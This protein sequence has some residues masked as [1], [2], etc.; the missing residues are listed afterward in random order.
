[1]PNSHISFRNLLDSVSQ[2]STYIVAAYNFDNT[3]IL[4]KNKQ[5][6]RNLDLYLRYYIA[7]E[8]L[9]DYSDKSQIYTAIDTL[10]ENSIRSFQ[11]A[12]PTGNEQS[13]FSLENIDGFLEK[14]DLLRNNNIAD[15]SVQKIVGTIE[16][17]MI[18][19]EEELNRLLKGES[20]KK[21][22]FVYRDPIKR[23]V[24]GLAQDVVSI[25]LDSP[26]HRIL[27]KAAL[28]IDNNHSNRILYDALYNEKY[29]PENSFGR[30]GGLFTSL[31]KKPEQNASSDEKFIYEKKAEFF[32]KIAK[33][34]MEESRFENQHSGPYLSYLWPSISLLSCDIKLLNL[35]AD[36]GETIDLHGI[37]DEFE[38]KKRAQFILTSV[39]NSSAGLLTKREI[40]D[41][42]KRRNMIY[43]E[44]H[45]SQSNDGL[46]DLI[47][48]VITA[49]QPQDILYQQFINLISK[50]SIH[51]TNLKYD[52][53]NLV[54][55]IEYDEPDQDENNNM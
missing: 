4:T 32:K 13:T 35:D 15:S 42:A 47:L 53:R 36:E 44:I 20:E 41:E 43:S 39:A 6:T 7:E 1:M 33:E 24:S 49:L 12:P 55:F 10:S 17:Y 22:I 38:E 19:S 37:I 52:E 16:K 18:D 45:K 48:E 25:Q 46:K 21:L 8:I 9:F 27:L 26:D 28:D 29:K 31:V 50:E 54:E 14:K 2:K 34:Y 3:I 40:K 5:A 11:Y 30:S 51:Y 23:V